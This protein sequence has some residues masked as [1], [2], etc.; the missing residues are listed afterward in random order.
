MADRMLFIGWGTPVRGREERGLEVFNES[1]GLYGRMQQ[2]GRIEQ[3][4][5]VLLDPAEDL[6]GYIELHGSREQLATLRASEDFRRTLVDASLIVDG[7]RLIEGFANE[8]VAGEM[9][10]YQESIGRVPQTA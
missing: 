9:A 3:F 7:L 1:I 10:I 8:G 4:D 5:V 6:G 2:E